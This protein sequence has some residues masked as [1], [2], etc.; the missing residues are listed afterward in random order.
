MLVKWLAQDLSRYS[1][2]PT[3]VNCLCETFCI[4]HLYSYFI[5][6]IRPKGNWIVRDEGAERKLRSR[7]TLRLKVVI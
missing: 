3:E 5:K 4:Y 1:Y 7:Y 2:V 6:S